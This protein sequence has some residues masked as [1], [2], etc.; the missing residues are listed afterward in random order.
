M[1]VLLEPCRPNPF[2]H[3]PQALALQALL[4]AFPV[5]D[6]NFSLV[7]KYFIGLASLNLHIRIVPF[8]PLCG[9]TSLPLG[10]G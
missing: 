3:I 9:G 4:L 7:A 1:Q 5:P 6:I 10:L 8:L 2:G